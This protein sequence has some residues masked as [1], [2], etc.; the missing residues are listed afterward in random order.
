M[1]T[2]ADIGHL[3]VTFLDE[4]VAWQLAHSETWGPDDGARRV[5]VTVLARAVAREARGRVHTVL[6]LGTRN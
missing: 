4:L 1:M 3:P 5:A 6:E 2:E